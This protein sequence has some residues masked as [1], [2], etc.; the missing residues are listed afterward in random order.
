[1]S[2]GLGAERSL[3]LDASR[4]DV[5]GFQHL[6]EQWKKQNDREADTSVSIRDQR[7]LIEM[8]YIAGGEADD[9]N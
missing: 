2:S 4:D 8:G 9:K 5:L 7:A 6:I 1:M 3:E